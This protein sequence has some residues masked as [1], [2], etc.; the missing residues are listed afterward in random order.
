M[1]QPD[2]GIT[3]DARERACIYCDKTEACIT[4]ASAVT[5]KY[6]VG[7]MEAKSWFLEEETLVH[8]LVSTLPLLRNSVPPQKASFP[9][10]ARYT[11]APD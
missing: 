2:H 10:I 11:L 8:Q 6:P 7:L 1:A 3:V 5:A 9:F 4:H